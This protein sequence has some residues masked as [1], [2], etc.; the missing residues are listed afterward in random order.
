MKRSIVATLVSVT[1]AASLAGITA[2]RLRYLRN[3]REELAA[4][5]YG[6]PKKPLTW[7]YFFKNYNGRN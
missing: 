2:T 3:T 7:K 6:G 4:L 5:P 1:I